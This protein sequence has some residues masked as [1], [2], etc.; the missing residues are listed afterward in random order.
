[1]AV[2]P[3]E[4]AAIVAAIAQFTRDTGSVAAP[5]LQPT[6]PWKRAALLEGAGY[7]PDQ[8]PTA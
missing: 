7:A 6:S 8:T 4:A 1:M 5:P 3:E 2:S